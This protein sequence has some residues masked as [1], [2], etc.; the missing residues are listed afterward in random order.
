MLYARLECNGKYEAIFP[1]ISVQT[2][3]LNHGRNKLGQYN[4]SAFF[5]RH[6]PSQREFLF[7]GDVEPD[8]IA[9]RPRTIHVWRAAAPKIPDTLSCI[10]IECSW[11]SGRKD[12]LL[13]GHLTPEHLGNELAALAAEVVKHRRMT[14]RCLEPDQSPARKKQRRNSVTPTFPD[15]YH[16]LVGVRVYIIHCKDGDARRPARDIILEECRQVVKEKGLGAEVLLASQGM[17]LGEKS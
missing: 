1:D 8:A 16:A 7:F 13:F 6:D 9:E 11:P 2:F 10:F 15:L 5:I 17:H 4:S 14:V 3:P 12:D